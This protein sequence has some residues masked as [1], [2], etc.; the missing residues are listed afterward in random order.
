M[1]LRI[2]GFIETETW[3]LVEKAFLSERIKLFLSISACESPLNPTFKLRS[4][5]PTESL[6]GF[7]GVVFIDAHYHEAF[8]VAILNEN[9]I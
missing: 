9:I 1:F 7:D 4:I 5:L 8:I 6:C 2:T 3:S